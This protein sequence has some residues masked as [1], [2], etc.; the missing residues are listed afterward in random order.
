MSKPVGRAES[1]DG[2]NKKQLPDAA[3]AAMCQEPYTALLKMDTE[4]FA[5]RVSWIPPFFLRYFICCPFAFDVQKMIQILEYRGRV[6][7]T[8]IQLYKKSPIW[9]G[10]GLNKINKQ[11]VCQQSEEPDK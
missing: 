5:F 8:S 11:I 4:L 9:E 3:T 10:Y 1:K 6:F 7:G 2:R